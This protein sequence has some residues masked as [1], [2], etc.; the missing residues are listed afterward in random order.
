MALADI[1]V[2]VFGVRRNDG[3]QRCLH[4]GDDFAGRSFASHQLPHQGGKTDVAPAGD[5]MI[6]Q[7]ADTLF[8]DLETDFGTTEHDDRLRRDRL[9]LGHEPRG[10]LDVPDIH[11]D[12]DDARSFRQQFLDDIL[13][14]LADHELAD[15]RGLPPLAK[16]RAQ[17]AQAERGMRVTGVEGSQQDLGHAAIIAVNA[18]SVGRWSIISPSGQFSRRQDLVNRRCTGGSHRRPPGT[19]RLR[20]GSHR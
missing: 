4:A 13:G 3:R 14:L 11:A 8:V 12:A 5:D 15:R 19:S 16:V 20:P 6:G 1:F 10:L 7:I 17:V 2:G 18:A 9:E